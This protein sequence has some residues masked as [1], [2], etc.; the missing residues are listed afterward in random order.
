VEL[1]KS[2]LFFIHKKLENLLTPVPVW[3]KS[4]RPG[5][6]VNRVELNERLGP[7]K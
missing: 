1:L 2:L 7:G 5:S 4:I 6:Q 3:K